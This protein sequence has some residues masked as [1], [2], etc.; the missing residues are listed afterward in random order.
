MEQY[1][2]WT[3]VPPRC[4]MRHICIGKGCE[5][6]RRTQPGLKMPLYVFNKLRVINNARYTPIPPPTGMAMEEIIH[7]GSPMNKECP[8]SY[9]KIMEKI[10]SITQM[11]YTTVFSSHG[12]WGKDM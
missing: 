8:R 2:F 1:V 10:V 7:V 4:T 11:R 6:D 5:G 3:C 12:S 9:V